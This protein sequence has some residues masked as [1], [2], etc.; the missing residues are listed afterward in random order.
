MVQTA[1]HIQTNEEI[2]QRFEPIPA[3][4]WADLQLLT[5]PDGLRLEGSREYFEPSRAFE[6]KGWA[7][8]RFVGRDLHDLIEY[9]RGRTGVSAAEHAA[10]KPRQKPGPKCSTRDDAIRRRLKNREHPEPSKSFCEAIRN[11]CADSRN[12]DRSPKRGYSDRAIQ[13][14]VRSI[15]LEM[16]KSNSS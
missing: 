3:E 16:T 1:N 8:V 12:S 6:F 5:M 9:S 13:R 2:A 7:F 4:D 11:D 15:Q 14:A 10:V